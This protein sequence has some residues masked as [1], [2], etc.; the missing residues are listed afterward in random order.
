MKKRKRDEIKNNESEGGV[1]LVLATTPSEQLRQ[2]V[3]RDTEKTPKAKKHKKE[4][5]HIEKEKKNKTESKKKKLK[6]E[7]KNKKNKMK[8]TQV[9][10]SA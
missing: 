7:K 10:K 1:A 9:R 3:S 6:K 2:G 4:N 5:E 8:D